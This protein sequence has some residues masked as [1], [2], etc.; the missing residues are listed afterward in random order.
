MP[1]IRLTYSRDIKREGTDH[2]DVSDDRARALVSQRRAVV[3]EDADELAALTKA[4]LVE[5]A[6]AAGVD[7][8]PKATKATIVGAIR[9]AE[10][11]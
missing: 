3:V 10:A 11:G 9:G 7:V 1:R 4:E 2:L 6:V 5:H 8:D